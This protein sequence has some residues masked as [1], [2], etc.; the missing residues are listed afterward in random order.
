M[1]TTR[2]EGR[3]FDLLDD[4]LVHLDGSAGPLRTDQLRLLIPAT[5][6]DDPAVQAFLHTGSND[7]PTDSVSMSMSP[8]PSVDSHRAPDSEDSNAPNTAVHSCHPSITGLYTFIF[9]NLL[10]RL[11]AETQSENDILESPTT[12]MVAPHPPEVNEPGT[13]PFTLFHQH[14]TPLFLMIFR[15]GSFGCGAYSS[16]YWPPAHSNPFPLDLYNQTPVFIAPNRAAQTSLRHPGGW[17]WRG[18]R[19]SSPP[20]S[21]AGTPP[22]ACPFHQEFGEYIAIFHFSNVPWEETAR[23]AMTSNMTSTNG[24]PDAGGEKEHVK[25]VCFNIYVSMSST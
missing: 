7:A 4:Q 3:N 2:G 13:V 21:S 25:R 5:T 1:F 14:S 12:L 16:A 20:E 22:I 17:S 11:P 19:L 23:T 18:S 24:D 15:F 10:A 6:H 8:I 9:W